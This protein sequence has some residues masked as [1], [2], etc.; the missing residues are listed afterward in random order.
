MPII[1]DKIIVNRWFSFYGKDEVKRLQFF[2]K[3]GI[4][5]VIRINKLRIDEEVLLNKLRSKG[6]VLEKTFLDGAFKVL[7]QKI[8]IGATNEFLLGYYA[9]QGLASQY[10][11]F[12]LQPR[13]DD[14]ILDMSAAPGG[15]TGHLSSLMNNNGLIIAIDVSK[16]RLSA[17]RSNLSRLAVQNVLA[18]HGRAEEIVPILQKFDKILLDAPCTGSGSICKQPNKE[19]IK[20]KSDIE[21][22]A[23]NQTIL[24]ETGIRALKIGG[25]LIYSTCS[26]EPEEGELQIIELMKKY[27]NELD[28]QTIPKSINIENKYISTLSDSNK[29]YYDLY[30]DKW[31]R[32]LPQEEFEG[33]FICKIKKIKEIE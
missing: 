3:N 23:K 2:N 26:L 18:F 16:K 14:L 28:V 4:N 15:K 11:S 19:W 22:L 5:T 25:E 6:I 9:I 10:V 29:K 7:R 17:L 20:E 12:L 13:K 21:R 27:S 30:K 33:F 8:S 32:I 24:L 31:L 1:T